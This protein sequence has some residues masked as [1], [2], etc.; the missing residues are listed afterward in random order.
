MFV[1]IVWFIVK[2][3]KSLAGHGAASNNTRMDSV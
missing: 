2:L 1:G 3:E